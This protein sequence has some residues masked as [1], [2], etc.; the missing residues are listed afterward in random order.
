MKALLKYTCFA[1]VGAV[2]FGAAQ[3][4]HGTGGNR[5]GRGFLGWCAYTAS[6]QKAYHDALHGG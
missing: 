5:P 2:A 3:T 6:Q 1:L 4:D